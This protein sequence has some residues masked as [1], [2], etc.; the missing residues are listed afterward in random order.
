MKHKFFTY[1]WHDAVIEKIEIID[2]QITI[3]ICLDGYDEPIKVLCS[4]VVGLTD[5]CMWEDTIIFT[6]TLEKVTKELPSFLQQ[7]RNA[8]YEECVHPN[9]LCLSFQLTNDIAFHI[10]CYNVEIVE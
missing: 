5:L 1:S 9:L 7:V 6:A 10:Y 3:T 2:N 4:D 8:H